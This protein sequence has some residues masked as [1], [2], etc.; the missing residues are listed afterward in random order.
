VRRIGLAG[1]ALLA[2][3]C[4]PYQVLDDA[5]S[6]P[7][8]LFAKESVALLLSNDL[9]TLSR[10]FTPDVAP[11]AT[12][13][14]LARI[15]TEIPAGEA[16]GPRIVGFES[17]RSGQ[18]RRATFTYEYAFP[19]EYLLALVVVDSSGPAPLIAGLHVKRMPDSLA[20]LN[21]FRL[22]GKSPRHFVVLALTVLVA[23]FV[24]LALVVCARTP[25]RRKWLW[26]LFVAVGFGKLTLNWTTGA[27]GFS[28]IAFQLLGASAFAAGAYAPW[29][30]GVSFPL[31]A[32]VFLA[33]RRRLHEQVARE[34]RSST[35]E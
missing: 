34:E 31:G 18:V 16:S 22:D 17:F 28:P 29:I 8:G 27:V 20:R 12:P 11:S 23:A 30:L 10:R 13:E 25:L 1:L 19:G 35:F 24:L 21:A 3:S 9:A 6:S 5:A 15:R 4:S 32:I 7:A 14:A 26:L 2:A 33:R